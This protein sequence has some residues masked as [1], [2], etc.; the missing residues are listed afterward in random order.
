MANV[1]QGLSPVLQ[2][3]DNDGMPIDVPARTVYARLAYTVPSIPVEAGRIQ[4]VRMESNYSSSVTFR[5]LQTDAA[6]Q[7]SLH[8]VAGFASG[9]CLRSTS[10]SIAI[11]SASPTALNFLEYLASRIVLRSTARTTLQLKDAFDNVA[12][13]VIASCRVGLYLYS[14]T[15]I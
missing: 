1:G 13:G 15:C 3:R 6:G 14:F 2:M 8:F 12:N 5:N 9:L 10:V 7:M 11:V 4:D